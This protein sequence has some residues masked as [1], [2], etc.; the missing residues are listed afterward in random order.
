MKKKQLIEVSKKREKKGN[1][2]SAVSLHNSSGLSGGTTSV[3]LPSIHVSKNAT[4][5]NKFNPRQFTQ[6]IAFDEN[7]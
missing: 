5:Y 7:G 3:K 4:K 6:Y 2:S 1:R